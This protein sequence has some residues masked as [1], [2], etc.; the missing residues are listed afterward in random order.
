MENILDRDLILPSYCSIK[1]SNRYEDIYAKLARQSLE[2]YFKKGV[3]LR[4]PLVH[5]KMLKEREGVLVLIKK[6][7]EV[8]GCKGTV[9]PATDCIAREI[10]KNVVEAGRGNNKFSKVR[11]E[12]LAELEYS[13][14]IIHD[15][16]TAKKEELNPKRYGIFVKAGSKSSCLL[17]NVY[18][19]ETAERQLE[20]ALK[21]AGISEDE[22]YTIEKFE[23]IKRGY[24]G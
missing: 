8:R 12:E 13:I 23:V 15:V 10:I 11:K 4:I 1:G 17:P 2:H 7:G 22:E 24:R 18:G 3:Y 5:E 6:H 20:R 21:K 16:K 9:H 14:Y 19:V